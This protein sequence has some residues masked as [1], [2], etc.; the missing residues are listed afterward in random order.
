[1]KKILLGLLLAAAAVPVNATDVYAGTRK[2]WLEKAEALKPQLTTTEVK[3]MCLVTPVRDAS[4]YQKDG[5]SRKV[6]K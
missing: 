3:P 6:P 4:A 2:A 5:A 1:M